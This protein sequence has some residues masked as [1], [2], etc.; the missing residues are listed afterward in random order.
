MTLKLRMLAQDR[1]QLEATELI[2]IKPLHKNEVKASNLL[3][4]AA[5]E[6]PPLQRANLLKEAQLLLDITS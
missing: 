4:L 6:R 5:M 1:L 2:I 3:V